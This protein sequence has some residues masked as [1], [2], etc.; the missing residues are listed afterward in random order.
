MILHTK[1]SDILFDIQFDIL[2]NMTK[3]DKVISIHNVT[4]L[5]T[6]ITTKAFV[7]SYNPKEY[8]CITE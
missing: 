8:S 1:K 6:V 7:W 2:F 5:T 3:I 4:F